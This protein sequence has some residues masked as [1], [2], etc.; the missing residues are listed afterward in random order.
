MLIPNVSRCICNN[1]VW[2]R[3]TVENNKEYIIYVLKDRILEET[4]KLFVFIKAKTTIK[5][6]R[7]L[8]TFSQTGLDIRVISQL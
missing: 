2:G 5:K 8:Y 1:V 3:T 6:R 4:L 7:H